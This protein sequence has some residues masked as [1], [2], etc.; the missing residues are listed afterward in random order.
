MYTI[1]TAAAAVGRNKSAILRAINAGKISI[2][3]DENGELQIDPAELHC[4]YPPLRSASM[5]MSNCACINRHCWRQFEDQASAARDAFQLQLMIARYTTADDNHYFGWDD[6]EDDNARSLADKFLNR[7]SMLA[8]R[9]EG[10]SY[11]YAGWYQRLLGLAERGWLP[12]VLSDYNSVSYEQIPLDD[13]R[14]TEWKTSNEEK[15]SL[16]LSSS[17]KIATELPGLMMVDFPQCLKH[18]PG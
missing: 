1:A 7:F 12:V 18:W 5:A 3:K 2:T 6:A 10:W 16:P 13:L 14:P 4:I 9:G 17:R 8:R 15:P 11:A